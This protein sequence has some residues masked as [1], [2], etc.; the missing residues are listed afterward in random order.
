T[1]SIGTS[2]VDVVRALGP[3]Y[4]VSGLGARRRW[5]E[6]AEQCAAVHPSAV[7]VADRTHAESLRA[8]L[9]GS[10]R[11]LVGPEGLGELASDPETDVVVAAIVG[12]AGLESTVAAVQA[13]KQVGLANKEALVVAG[14][15]IVPLARRTGAQL[16]PIDSEHS[17][18]FQ[19]M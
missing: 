4:R 13:G 12:A 8:M 14:S 18:I 5:R 2:T 6:L 1:G 16:L 7:A 15:V 3:G 11:L 19:S 17:A 10:T 9:N